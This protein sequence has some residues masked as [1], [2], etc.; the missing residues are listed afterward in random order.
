MF[1]IIFLDAV[2]EQTSKYNI[3]AYFIVY[4]KLPLSIPRLI[5][6]NMAQWLVEK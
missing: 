6:P 5:K 4:K 3:L 2:N 1:V